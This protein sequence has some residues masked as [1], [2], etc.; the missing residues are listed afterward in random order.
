MDRMKE[1]K[2]TIE[3]RW[4]TLNQSYNGCCIREDDHKTPGKIVNLGDGAGLTRLGITSKNF[5]NVLPASFWSTSTSF[6]TA[7]P[8]AKQF[9]RDQEWHH[10]NGDRIAADG[11][12]A[13]LL[14]FAVNNNVPHA[15]KVL[16]GVL[17]VDSDGILGQATIAELNS[18][19]PVITEK[20]FRAEWAAYYHRLVDANPNDQKFLAGWL[21]RAAFPFPS[22]LVPNIYV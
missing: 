19:D 9:Y 16:Q 18:K 14:S 6:E 1:L 8:I 12:A 7:L 22:S 4:Q 20:L 13:A 17:Q 3:N 5:G 10:I 2:S 11:I 21:N 15:V